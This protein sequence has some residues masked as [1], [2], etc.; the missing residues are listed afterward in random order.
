MDLCPAS[1]FFFFSTFDMDKL[2]EIRWH[3]WK[4]G[5]KVND[6]AKF[7]SDLSKTNEGIR[8]GGAQT[9]KFAELYLRSLTPYHFQ[10]WLFYYFQFLLLKRLSCLIKSRRFH[11]C[12]KLGLL[13]IMSHQELLV[14]IHYRAFVW[15]GYKLMTSSKDA[16]C[17]VPYS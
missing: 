16:M 1:S 13:N 17:P 6:I 11:G 14:P 4:K 3:H 8:R 9:G 12:F 15:A 2:K 10:I 7:E 5:L